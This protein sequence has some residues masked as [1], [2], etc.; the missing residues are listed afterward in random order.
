M[1]LQVF[2]LSESSTAIW[3]RYLLNC[4]KNS[5]FK[6]IL[7]NNFDPVFQVLA[8]LRIWETFQFYIMFA[9]FS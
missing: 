7:E 3:Q 2:F 9:N 6:K 1:I 8:S 4:E 5:T